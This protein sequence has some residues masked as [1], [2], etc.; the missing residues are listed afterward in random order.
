MPWAL[1]GYSPTQAQLYDEVLALEQM[2]TTGGGWQ[3]QVGGLM[4]GIKLVTSESGLL[5]KINAHPL[6]LTAAV[7]Q[8]L[9]DWM[10][11]IY[12]GP[13]RLAKNL[14]HMMVAKWMAREPNI[15]KSLGELATL[16]LDM[17][18]A[19]EAGDVTGFGE[20]VGRHWQVNK[21]MDPGCANPF[22]DRVFE[23]ARPYINGGKLAGAG[24]GDLESLLR[25]TVMLL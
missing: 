6:Q 5:Q 20:L 16:A 19:L 12:T 24:G 25:E 11:L 3:D 2:L 15:V 13:Q 23:I 22:I 4:G 9:T 21:Q 7:M 14:L 1:A 18:H 10:L 17:R 8:E